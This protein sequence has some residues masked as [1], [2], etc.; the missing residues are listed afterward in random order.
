MELKRIAETIFE[1]EKEMDLFNKSI[2]G[3]Y[4]WNLVRFPFYRKITTQ[5]GVRGVAHTAYKVD[6]FTN[7]YKHVL[8]ATNAAVFHNPHFSSECDLLFFGH[9][10]RKMMED[11]FWWDI[12]C[13]PV[14]NELKSRYKC[15][16]IEKP[17]YP[18][19]KKPAKTKGIRYLDFHVLLGTLYFKLATPGFSLTK[20]D[21]NLLEQIQCFIRDRLQ[22]I[23]DPVQNHQ[24]RGFNPDLKKIVSIALWERKKLLPIYVRV[25]KK[26]NPRL[27]L[28]VVGYANYTFIEACRRLNVPVL[29]LQHGFMSRYHLGY[30]YPH[31][32]PA[33]N[34]L[35]DYLLTFGDHWKNLVDFAIPQENILSAGYP[36]FDSE[37]NKYKQP[38]AGP[39]KNQILFISQGTAGKQIS[40]FAVETSELLEK[41]GN[42]SCQVVYKLHP[43]EYDRWKTEY[44]WLV[45]SNIKIIEDDSIP[46]Y[47][48]IAQSK[49]LVGLSSTV[50]YET[51]GLMDRLGID[52]KIFL[53]DL[54]GIETME[55]VI[56]SGAAYKTAAPVELIENLESPTYKQRC[57]PNT[58]P[59]PI[60]VPESKVLHKNGN[61]Q[62]AFDANLLFRP[63]SLRNIS[64]IVEELVHENR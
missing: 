62:S 25:L 56:R 61:L 26:M 13:D 63:D 21:E 43:G 47:K 50:I 37:A 6:S 42:P 10:R 33:N 2:Q 11:G 49:I 59:H 38:F 35:P 22:N 28:M 19:H 41:S 64:R 29:E 23:R 54:P 16:L 1:A 55:T 48:L 7:K 57:S 34:A 39:R 40:R 27:V 46:L 17:V 15:L 32:K 18:D 9:P 52:L 20:D 36:Y 30:S 53:L 24:G 5:T 31:A 60:H 8:N 14:I 4:F 12:Y 44:P 45:D 3:V 58:N 51:I